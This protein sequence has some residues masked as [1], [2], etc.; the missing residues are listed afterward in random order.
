MKER[1]KKECLKM[2]QE[3]IGS[4]I[5][6]LHRTEILIFYY[7]QFHQRLGLSHFPKK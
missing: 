1:E 4:F 3:G 5:F 6:S 7:L 2:S